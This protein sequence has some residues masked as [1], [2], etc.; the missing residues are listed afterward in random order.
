VLAGT[1]TLLLI[2]NVRNAWDLMLFLAGK[3]VDTT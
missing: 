2:D 3:H 1:V